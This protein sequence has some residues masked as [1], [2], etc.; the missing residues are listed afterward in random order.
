MCEPSIDPGR[1]DRV[2]GHPRRAVLRPAPRAATAASPVGRAVGTA[3]GYIAPQLGIS[4]DKDDER[5]CRGPTNFKVR[6][7]C[8]RSER[9]SATNPGPVLD[10]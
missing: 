2:G 5:S 7:A 1:A 3:G 4:G 10:A 8:I 6:S 9:G